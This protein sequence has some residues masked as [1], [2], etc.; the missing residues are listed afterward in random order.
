MINIKNLII[1]KRKLNVPYPYGQSWP[2]QN[3]GETTNLFNRT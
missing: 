3:Y 2:F 1:L